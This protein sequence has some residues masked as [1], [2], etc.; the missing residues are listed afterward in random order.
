MADSEANSAPDYIDSYQEN[1]TDPLDPTIK[2]V[3]ERLQDANIRAGV[4][5]PYANDVE[6]FTDL[7][8]KD[9]K[10]KGYLNING[11]PDICFLIRCLNEDH[12]VTRELDKGV[13][14][15][16]GK[17]LNVLNPRLL[18]RRKPG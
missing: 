5:K 18:T 11:P 13:F 17:E 16:S 3:T 4:I 9:C 15:I 10:V 6:K 2:S 12:E 7:E 1:V 14:L 8:L